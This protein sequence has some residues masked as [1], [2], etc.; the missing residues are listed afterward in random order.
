MMND[1]VQW[2]GGGNACA[3]EYCRE[4]LNRKRYDLPSPTIGMN[5]SK[6]TTTGIYRLEEV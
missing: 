1:D 2:F 4:S 5:F 6:T 3:C